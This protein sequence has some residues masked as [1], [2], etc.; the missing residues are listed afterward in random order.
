M[1]CLATWIDLSWGWLD[2]SS[3]LVKRL[4]AS[5]LV[6]QI[7]GEGGCAKEFEGRFAYGQVLS[8]YGH[9]RALRDAH[10]LWAQSE[11]VFGSE[12]KLDTTG[13]VVLTRSW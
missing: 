10:L 5:L 13:F 4:R 12:D 6:E 11:C 3:W 9:S 7:A 1:F 2:H 8:R